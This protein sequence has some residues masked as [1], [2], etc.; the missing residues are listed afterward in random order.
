MR[1]TLLPH[2]LA[3]LVEFGEAEAY[4]E[5]F[6]LAS[7]DLNLQ[8]EQ[9]GSAVLLLAPAVDILLLNRVIGLGL[10]EPATEAMVAALVARYQAAG[11]QNFG[12]QL[13]PQ[14]A[15][16]DLPAW[17]EKHNLVPRDRWV[18]VFQSA[19]TPAHVATDL[20]FERIGESH[21]TTWAEV[22][23]AAFDMPL[24][25]A[26]GLARSVGQPSWRHYLAWDG[27]Q[28]VAT[29]ALFLHGRVGWLGAAGTLRSHR[30]RGAQGALMARRIQD[31]AAAGCEWVITETG[32]DTAERPNPSFHN[33]RRTG[34]QI[35]YLRPN[36]MRRI[37]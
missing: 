37:P 34:F 33:M 12:V 23:S 7:P 19:Q 14:A 24:P 16:A 3:Q 6:R 1:D 15:P 9:I 25:L 35:A 5:F 10:R 30:R 8:A 2:E 13:S 17:L 32:E 28:P 31:S 29:A 26:V 22:A 4:R 18:K 20:R 36:Y 27:P 21:L 11:V